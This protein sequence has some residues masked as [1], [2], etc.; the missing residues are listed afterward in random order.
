MRRMQVLR[1]MLFITYFHKEMDEFGLDYDKEI[2]DK[3]SD[4]AKRKNKPKH[5]E[6]KSTNDHG[7]IPEGVVKSGSDTGK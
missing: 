7:T 4:E 3:V 1:L 2:L 6:T 5:V